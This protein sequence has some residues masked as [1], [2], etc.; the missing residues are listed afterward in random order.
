V[1]QLGQ[2]SLKC[3]KIRRDF[4]SEVWWSLGG[5]NYIFNKMST[6]L[7]TPYFMAFNNIDCSIRFKE[8]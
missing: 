2:T 4:K 5:S 3:S 1:P 6:S 7:K 8:I